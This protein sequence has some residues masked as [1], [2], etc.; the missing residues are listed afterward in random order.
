VK[1]SLSGRRVLVTGA[2]RGLGAETAVQL[3]RRGALV[4]LVG[5]EPDL[6][7]QVRIRI[8]SQHIALPA[9]V[10][11]QA[12]L[13]D[14]FGRTVERFGGIDAVI[15]NAGVSNTTPLSVGSAAAH[16]RTIDVNLGGALRTASCAFPRLRATR[17]YLVFIASV[18]SFAVMPGMATYCATKAGVESLAAGLRM[19]WRHHGIRVGTVHPT[20]V[21][22]DLVRNAGTDTP[23]FERL[24]TKLPGALGSTMEAADVASIIVNAVKHRRRRAYAPGSLAALSAG[25]S[26]MLSALGERF[27]EKRLDLDNSMP[28]LERE[29]LSTGREFGLHTPDP[30]QTLTQAEIASRSQV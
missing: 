26:L 24:R 16:V 4:S 15:A 9:D 1:S 19:E 5:L 3:A 17:G 21:D 13:E 14:A 28:R 11:N 6:L 18:G 23:T 10:T 25:R 7:E 20:F 12:E 22:T 8:G 29:S 27:L 2:A 30:T